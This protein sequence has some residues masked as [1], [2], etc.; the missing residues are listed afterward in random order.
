[1]RYN[2]LYASE[3]EI[4]IPGDFSLHAGDAFILMHHQHRRTQRMTILT[5][6]LVVY[7]LYRHCAIWL[8]LKELIPN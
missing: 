3:I 1:M 6:K 7:I 4:T 8:M 2:Q 5:V